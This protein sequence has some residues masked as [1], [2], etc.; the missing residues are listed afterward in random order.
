MI[1][2]LAVRCLSVRLIPPSDFLSAMLGAL[3]DARRAALSTVGQQQQSK[4]RAHVR[5]R[6]LSNPM[7]PSA[8]F[9]RVAVR[10]GGMLL[11]LKVASVRHVTFGIPCTAGGLYVSQVPEARVRVPFR[12][13]LHFEGGN[14]R[15]VQ[16]RYLCKSGEAFRPKTSRHFFV[17]RAWTGCC[18][19]SNIISNLSLPPLRLF[20]VGSSY[21]QNT[22]FAWSAMCAF[23]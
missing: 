13:L 6:R 16:P 23:C 17:H 4:A 1:T 14:K 18:W 12:C 2:A 5:E 19:F 15:G 8:R 10:C 7:P 9:R 11:G 22:F 20:G 21:R 3:P